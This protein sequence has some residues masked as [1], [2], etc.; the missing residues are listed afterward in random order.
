MVHVDDRRLAVEDSGT[1]FPILVQSGFGSR[2]L[3]PGAVRDA[4]RAGLRLISYDRPGLGQSDPQP[5]RKVAD[6]ISDVMAIVD[7]LEIDRLAVW[8]SSGG[9]P[10][11][12]AAA[13]GLGDVVTSVGL[14]SPIGPYG[15]P[16]L[17]FTEGMGVDADFHDEIAELLQDPMTARAGFM[18][19]ARDMLA[20]QGFPDSWL[21]RWGDLAGKDAAHSVEWAEYLAA[22]AVDGFG[23]DGEGW[24]EDW[25]ATFL[26][27]GLDLTQVKAP[28]SLW[29]GMQDEM[30]PQ[31]HARWYASHLSDIDLHLLPDIDHTNIDENLR[32]TA[33]QWFAQYAT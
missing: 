16:Q 20:S 27:W 19:R 15:T 7:T 30:V 10:Y 26:P 6:S 32:S 28:V 24:W 29:H 11:A 3:F 14:F 8:G 33:L 25:C 2:H 31:A 12:V 4:N 13:A 5:G 21:R 23:A 22:C 9:G 17:D 18:E 1:G